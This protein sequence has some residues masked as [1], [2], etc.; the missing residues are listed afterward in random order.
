MTT[1][2]IKS[3]ITDSLMD[4]PRYK[5]MTAAEFEEEMEALARMAAR[6][7]ESLVRYQKLDP[8]TAKSEAIRSG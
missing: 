8:I 7:M 3:V 6:E 2:A 4:Q 5:K 1:Q